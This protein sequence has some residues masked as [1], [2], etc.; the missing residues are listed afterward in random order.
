VAA[1]AGDGRSYRD[2]VMMETATVLRQLG[3]KSDHEA[4]AYTRPLLS[5]A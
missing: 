1:I 2:D 4:G 3:L 5:S